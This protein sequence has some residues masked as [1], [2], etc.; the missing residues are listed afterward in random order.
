MKLRLMLGLLLG[1][2]ARGAFYLRWCCFS[3]SAAM[4]GPGAMRVRGQGRPTAS[5]L[6]CWA[7]WGASRTQSLR[8]ADPSAR[9]W[10]GRDV[11]RRHRG[12]RPARGRH[13]YI[14]KQ[15]R[16]LLMDSTCME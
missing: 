12:E 7:R 3:Q 15:L 8:L 4:L 11:R 13:L 10:L 9:R 14:T 1:E 6:L 16:H 2:V 5:T